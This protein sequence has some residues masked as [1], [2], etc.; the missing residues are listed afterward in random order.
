MFKYIAPVLALFPVLAVA[1]IQPVTTYPPPV[2]LSGL[3]VPPTG[4][5]FNNPSLTVATPGGIIYIAAGKN[6]SG[7]PASLAVAGSTYA[8]PANTTTYD[9]VGLDGKIFHQAASSCP[10]SSML[11]QVV[12]TGTSWIN[13]IQGR[14]PVWPGAYPMPEVAE[15]P[16]AIGSL[17]GVPLLNQSALFKGNWLGVLSNDPT[18][19]CKEGLAT[20]CFLDNDPIIPIVRLVPGRTPMPNDYLGNVQFDGASAKTPNQVSVVYG[21]VQSRIVDPNA[22]TI[23]GRVDIGTADPGNDGGSFTRFACGKGCFMAGSKGDVPGGDMGPY[24]INAGT[25]YVAGVPLAEYIKS[26]VARGF[27]DA[28]MADMATNGHADTVSA[29]MH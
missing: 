28:R 6:S 7:V 25:Y 9:C 13:W 12:D 5:Q 24:T 23:S 3:V 14:I 8:Y 29:L 17:G 15:I 18:E 11:L 2:I 21:I 27:A 1:Q 10:S 22:A 20:A 19:V 16:Q 4:G 26:Q